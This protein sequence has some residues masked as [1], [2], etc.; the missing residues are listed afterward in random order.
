MG[1]RISRLIPF[2]TSG[3]GI[4]RDM[5][6]EYSFIKVTTMMSLAPGGS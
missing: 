5:R 6:T 2:E 3:S 1:T 4:L